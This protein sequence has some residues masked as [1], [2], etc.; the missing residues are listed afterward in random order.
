MFGGCRSRT[1]QSDCEVTCLDTLA[2]CMRAFP[3]VDSSPLA[4]GGRPGRYEGNRQVAGQFGD[5]GHLGV[6]MEWIDPVDDDQ[7]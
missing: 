4:R 1:T 3:D 5:G 7:P 6:A 2:G